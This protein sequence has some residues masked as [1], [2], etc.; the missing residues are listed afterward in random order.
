MRYFFTIILLFI[1][2]FGCNYSQEEMK[3]YAISYNKTIDPLIVKEKTL[4]KE[5]KRLSSESNSIIVDEEDTLQHKYFT[6]NRLYSDFLD[7]INK[8]G[9]EL[10]VIKHHDDC[11][12]L[13]NSAESL[14]IKYQK[15]AFNEYKEII[16]IV[17]TPYIDFEESDKRKKA[18]AK[19]INNELNSAVNDFSND[20][21]V[22]CDRFGIDNLD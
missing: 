21:Q 18:I 15:V 13:K 22:F 16:S 5:I 17:K 12:E 10:K 4:I 19:L 3:N 8:S 1:V 6:L 9:D 7:Q 14:L 2:L 20:L 11:V